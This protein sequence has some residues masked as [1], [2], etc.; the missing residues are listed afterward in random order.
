MGDQKELK[1]FY[2]KLKA[3]QLQER[4]YWLLQKKKIVIDKFTDKQQ[5][6]KEWLKQ[7]E[8]ECDRYKVLNE[9]KKVQS[10]GL[11]LKESVKE[12]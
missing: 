7:F 10:L 9:N 4:Y 5:N 8:K 6:A 3:Q 1:E 12:W 2:M 11:F